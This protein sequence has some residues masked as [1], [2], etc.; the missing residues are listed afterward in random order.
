MKLKLIASQTH[1]DV[2]SSCCWSPDNKLYSLSDDKTILIWDYT[3][4]F[5]SKFMDLDSYCTLLY[6]LRMEHNSKIRKRIISN[7]FFRR[8]SYNNEQNR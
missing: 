6:F 7:W 5:N 3:G 1:T 8:N 4:D 2:V